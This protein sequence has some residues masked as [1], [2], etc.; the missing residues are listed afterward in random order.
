MAHEGMG[1]L[2]VWDTSW[3]TIDCVAIDS[4]VIDIVEYILCYIVCCARGYGDA[5]CLGH[6]MG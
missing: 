6:F 1:T 4:V 3:D 2:D 5:E